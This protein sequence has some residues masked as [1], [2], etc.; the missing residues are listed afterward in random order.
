L[1]IAREAY[2]GKLR[3]VSGYRRA[4]PVHIHDFVMLKALADTHAA[5]AAAFL[6][7]GLHD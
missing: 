6:R 1:V 7:A 2:A 4:L 3:E 5:K